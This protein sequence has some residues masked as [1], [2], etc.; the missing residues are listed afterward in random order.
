MDNLF[1]EIQTLIVN[2]FIFE[3]YMT[4]DGRTYVKITG[5]SGYQ[6]VTIRDLLHSG[7]QLADIL[8]DMRTMHNQDLEKHQF[9]G[10]VERST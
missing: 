2:D 7:E 6:I 5:P 1:R 9:G 8:K 4:R 10:H 3:I